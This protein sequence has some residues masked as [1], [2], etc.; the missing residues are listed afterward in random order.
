[1]VGAS[2]DAGG[3]LRGGGASSSRAAGSAPAAVV[4]L[5]REA[6]TSTLFGESPESNE[7]FCPNATC[8]A[9]KDVNVAVE[10]LAPEPQRVE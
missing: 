5:T 8:V 10:R 3:G 6:K 7:T 2:D 9:G 1:M 4:Q